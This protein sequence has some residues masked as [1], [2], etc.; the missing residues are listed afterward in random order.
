MTGDGDHTL[1]YRAVDKLGHLEAAKTLSFKIDATAPVLA[2]LPESCVIWPPNDRMIA[3]ATIAA[4][5][6]LSG[7]APASLVIAV[8]S[9][10]PINQTDVRINGVAVQVRA[11]RLGSGNGRIYNITAEAA[12]LAGNTVTAESTC[13]V[14]HDQSGK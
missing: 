14:P 9:N 12:D 8:N 13:V 11:N 5:D 10:E 2:G 7:V 3:V 1:H 6:S 4:S